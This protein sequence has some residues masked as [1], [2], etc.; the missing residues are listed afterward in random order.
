MIKSVWFWAWS[1]SW[2]VGSSPGCSS[3]MLGLGLGSKMTRFLGNKGGCEAMEP[4]V[5][6]R[7]GWNGFSFLFIWDQPKFFLSVVTSSKYQGE[8]HAVYWNRKQLA[9]NLM[10]SFLSPLGIA[11]CVLAWGDICCP[12]LEGGSRA[13]Q[14][15]SRADNPGPAQ[16]CSVCH[17]FV[18]GWHTLPACLLSFSWIT[19]LCHFLLFWMLL[20]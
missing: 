11:F 1:P 18:Y 16:P 5:F 14:G 19:A 6:N 9:L 15:L 10:N 2:G 12:C 4:S 17:G 7:R 20:N 3:A 13:A 8:R